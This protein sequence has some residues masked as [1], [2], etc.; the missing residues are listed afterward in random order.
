VYIMHP[1]WPLDEVCLPEYYPDIPG[2]K[3]DTAE[4][5]AVHLSSTLTL[6][7]I[8]KDSSSQAL[9]RH[10]KDS[11]YRCFLPNLAGF[12]DLRCEGPSFP[13]CPVRIEAHRPGLGEEYDPAIADFGYRAPLTPH[14]ARPRL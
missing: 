7:R 12:T 5:K 9:P 8:P 13:Y 11:A 6:E 3:D 4:N 2:E 10:P 1:R 14:L